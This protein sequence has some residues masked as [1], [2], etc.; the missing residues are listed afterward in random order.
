MKNFEHQSDVFAASHSGAMLWSFFKLFQVHPLGFFFAPA[1]C[2]CSLQQPPRA[3]PLRWCATCP[4]SHLRS[5]NRCSIFERRAECQ[6]WNQ[7]WN[8]CR[9]RKKSKSSI[10]LSQQYQQLKL[11]LCTNFSI[12]EFES[13]VFTGLWKT[14]RR[15][16]NM[17]NFKASNPS[18]GGQ[19]WE[20]MKK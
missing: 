2:R 16:W 15:T 12:F 3:V 14:C 6:V 19:T 11:K 10:C 17:N 18:P 5:W 13:W 20:K 9:L 4:A 8:P 7:Y 1:R